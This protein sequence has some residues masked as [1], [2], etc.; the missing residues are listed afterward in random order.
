MSWGE[1]PAPQLGGNWK[2]YL[3]GLFYQVKGTRGGVIRTFFKAKISFLWKSI[4]IKINMICVSKVNEI[5]TKMEQEQSLQLKI[6]F[7]LG[8]N[9]KVV[10]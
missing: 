7:L 8:Y 4:K 9:L 2:F 3:G 1:I 5:K 6:L 10:A